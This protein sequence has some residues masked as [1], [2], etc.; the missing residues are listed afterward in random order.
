MTK[1]KILTDEEQ[2]KIGQHLILQILMKPIWSGFATDS[3]VEYLFKEEMKL[4][5]EQGTHLLAKL[6]D[7]TSSLGQALVRNLEEGLIKE[8]VIGE[9]CWN[10]TPRGKTRFFNKP[11]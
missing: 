9:I 10:I 2:I 4:L 7:G 3:T 1:K 6:K 5:N 8:R 11:Y